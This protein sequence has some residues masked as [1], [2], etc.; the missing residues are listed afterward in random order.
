MIANSIFILVAILCCVVLYLCLRWE[1]R[2]LDATQG[3][4]NDEEEAGSDGG[5]NPARQRV[6]SA[7]MPGFRYML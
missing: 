2:K 6:A 3:D 5:K 7:Q 1:N 4:T